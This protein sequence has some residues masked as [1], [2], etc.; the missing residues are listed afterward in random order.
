MNGVQKGLQFYKGKPM[1]CWIANNFKKALGKDALINCNSD[2]DAYHDISP[3]L[4][5]D[6]NNKRAGPLEGL[7]SLM[8]ATHAD[9]LITS[10]CD[11]PC[12]SD[13]F[14]PRLLQRLDMVL[15]NSDKDEHG[16][17]LIG[18]ESEHRKHPLHLCISTQLKVSLR[19]AIDTGQSRVM[20]WVLSQQPIWVSFNDSPGNFQN[21]NTISELQ[22]A[23]SES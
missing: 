16:K 19:Q 13:D 4:C 10:P 6:R 8:S 11:T 17:I 2:V 9:Y 23:N 1:A 5:H 3:R 14:V 22:T 12:L 21:F 20:S 18:V 7:L 15:E